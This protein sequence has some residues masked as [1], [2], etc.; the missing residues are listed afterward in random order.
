MSSCSSA[1]CPPRSSALPPGQQFC[2]PLSAQRLRCAASKPR[3]STRRSA[4]TRAHTALVFAWTVSRQDG[5]NHL[6]VVVDRSASTR[7]RR[8][9]SAARSARTTAA[10]PSAT[11][12]RC[13]EWRQRLD[14]AQVRR[15]RAERAGTW[16][17]A[18]LC[19]QNIAQ[20]AGRFSV[21]AVARLRIKDRTSFPQSSRAQT[22]STGAEVSALFVHPPSKARRDPRR[23]GPAAASCVQTVDEADADV[24]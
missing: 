19:T 13:G 15:A 20:E 9:Y 8:W 4:I 16:L 2:C 17:C 21:K 6:G 1:P 7:I 14:P 24:L 10:R 22:A 18:C 5:P 23:A 3:R 12:P 11:T